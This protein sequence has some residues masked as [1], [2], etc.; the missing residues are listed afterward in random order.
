MGWSNWV[1][2]PFDGS[3]NI[4]LSGL[5]EAPNSSGIYAIATK[6]GWSYNTQYVGRS[7]R[8]IRGRLQNHLSGRGNRVVRGILENKKERPSDPTQALYFAFLETREHKLI[9]AAYIDAEDRPVGNLIR[10]RLPEGLRENEVY[11][12]ELE[13]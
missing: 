3:G 6:T 12:S 7:G 2:C 10:A 5:G 11:T 13:D 8:S 9:E 4:D 1:E